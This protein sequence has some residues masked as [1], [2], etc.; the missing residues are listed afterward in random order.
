M[1][2]CINHPERETSYICMKHNVYLC[3]ECLQCRDPELYCKF[4]ESCPIWFMTKKKAGLDA[5]L[6]PDGAK[7]TPP[8]H[9]VVFRTRCK[10]D[11]RA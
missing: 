1:G 5:D 6:A 8:E 10:G 4:R 7:D 11:S 3:D 9:R 2:T